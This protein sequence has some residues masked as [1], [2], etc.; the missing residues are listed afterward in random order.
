MRGASGSGKS[1]IANQLM[2]KAADIGR[3]RY[4]SADL[5]FLDDDGYHFMAGQLG[6][7]H[8]WCQEQCEISMNAS[9]ETVVVDNTSTM[10]KEM[11]PYIFLA[12]KHGY[13]VEFVEPT[14]PWAFDPQGCFERNIHGVPLETIQKQI[15]RYQKDP[16]VDKILGIKGEE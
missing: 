6:L 15:A 2:N 10:F 5:W 14:T 3:S 13:E 16:S 8:R 4:L 12:Q 7:A 9:T 1:F 11:R